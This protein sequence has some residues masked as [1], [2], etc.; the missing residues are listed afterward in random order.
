MPPK[1]TTSKEMIIEAGYSIADEEGIGQVNCRAIAKMLGCSTQPVFSR[2]PNMEELKEEIFNYACNELEKSIA[3]RLEGS[4]DYSLLEISVTALADLARN[5]KNLYKLIY[6]SDFR[7]E[8]TFLE[9]R[10]KYQTNKLIIK[11]LT[12]RYKIDAE[13]VEGIFERI[14]LLA[15]GIC[16]VIATTTMDYSNEYVTR[17][18]D[19][20]LKDA[21]LNCETIEKMD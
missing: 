12:N 2:F 9:E 4:K 13:R 3:D 14:S 19:D 18:I 17:I 16:T 20:A 21:I 7:S 1:I 8:K 5:H 11:E 6:L 15:H 10:E